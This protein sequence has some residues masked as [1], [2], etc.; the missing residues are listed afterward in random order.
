MNFLLSIEASVKLAHCF[1]A[2]K[3]MDENQTNLNQLSLWLVF[4]LEN[5]AVAGEMSFPTQSG[6]DSVR[7]LFPCAADAIISQ[8]AA[9]IWCTDPPRLISPDV[10]P[11]FFLS[12]AFS[13]FLSL[14][15]PSPIS[16]PLPSSSSSSCYL[17]SYPSFICTQTCTY[18]TFHIL[19]CSPWGGTQLRDRIVCQGKATEKCPENTVASI[20]FKKDSH[21][22]LMHHHHHPT[23]ILALLS[24]ELSSVKLCRESTGRTPRPWETRFS[25]WPHF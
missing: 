5:L 2:C 11:H 1:C 17:G 18:A 20:I 7:S 21:H 4:T 3:L 22:W 25:V 24:S 14:L 6:S 23:S 15:A 13:L 19:C 16:L 10:T 8:T 9:V 12:P